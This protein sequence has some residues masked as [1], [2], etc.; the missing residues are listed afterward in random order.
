MRC[1]HASAKIKSRTLPSAESFSECKCEVYKSEIDSLSKKL[2]E[3]SSELS[4]VRQKLS[5]FEEVKKDLEDIKREL[6]ILRKT[7][8]TGGGCGNECNLISGGSPS[9]PPPPPPPPMYIS[10]PIVR[11]RVLKKSC[12]NK[13]NEHS[14]PRITLDDILKVK[15]RKTAVS[16]DVVLSLYL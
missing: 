3:M 11:P 13:V 4:D 8:S 5:Q 7:K 12:D 14:R 2:D 1:V 15:L 16:I 9:P 6:E 10:V